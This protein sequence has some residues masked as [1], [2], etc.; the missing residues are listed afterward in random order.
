M[1][2]A[3]RVLI[4]FKRDVHYHNFKRLKYFINHPSNPSYNYIYY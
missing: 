4:I 2:G 3:L 1:L